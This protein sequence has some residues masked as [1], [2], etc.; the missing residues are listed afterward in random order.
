MIQQVGLGTFGVSVTLVLDSQRLNGG[1]FAGIQDP[2][3]NGGVIG[4]AGHQATQRL[5][6]KDHLALA[7][8]AH[9]RIA[10]HSADGGRVTDEQR[11]RTELGGGPGGLNTGVAAA[12]H[13]GGPAGMGRGKRERE[14][15]WAVIR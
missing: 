12:D 14:E 9:G 3:M 2:G 7:G 11:H 10:G 1:A 5:Q 8:A 15:G 4:Q 6:L 13:N